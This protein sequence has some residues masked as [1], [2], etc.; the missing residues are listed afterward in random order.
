MYKFRVQIYIIR[1][2]EH[3]FQKFYGFKSLVKLEGWGKNQNLQ[4]YA[5][6]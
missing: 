4:R 3:A 1:D 2:N 6:F 5:F